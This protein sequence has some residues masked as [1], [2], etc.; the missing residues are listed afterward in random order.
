MSDESMKLPQGMCCGVCSLFKKCE[1]IFG[2]KPT[3][4]ECDFYPVRFSVS[5]LRFLQECSE[6]DRLRGEN[7]KLQARVAELEAAQR[8]IPVEEQL[9]DDE[10]YFQVALVGG[11]IADTHCFFVKNPINWQG[12]HFVSGWYPI[13]TNTKI[14]NVT[15]WMPLPAEPEVTK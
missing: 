9:P 3:S 5:P 13:G 4:Q 14:E 11:Y 1:K 7:A 12:Q 8:W 2:C 10:G 6:S 15:H